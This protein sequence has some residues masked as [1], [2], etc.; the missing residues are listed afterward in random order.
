[1]VLPSVWTS[2]LLDCKDLEMS[3]LENF[4]MYKGSIIQ[5][6]TMQPLCNPSQARHQM[7][8]N[9]LIHMAQYDRVELTRYL[10]V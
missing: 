7:L 1:M 2:F 5:M 4:L 10:D 3:D 9:N 6:L 8:L